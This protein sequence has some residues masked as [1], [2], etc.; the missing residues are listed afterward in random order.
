[1]KVKLFIVVL[2]SSCDIFYPSVYLVPEDVQPHIDNFINEGALRGRDIVID[3]IEVQMTSIS[4][5]LTPAN[6]QMRHE[7]IVLRLDKI[8]WDNEKD[9][10]KRE[11]I[12]AHELAHKVLNR[13]HVPSDSLSLMNAKPNLNKYESFREYFLD[14]LFK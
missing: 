10:F 3:N 5:D 11:A 7:T 13:D 12:I 6:V 4:N 1:M 9:L 2:L 14:E 8:K